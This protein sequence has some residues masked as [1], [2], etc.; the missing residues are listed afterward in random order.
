MHLTRISM[1]V[2]E[3]VQ[4]LNL[5]ASMLRV[6]QWSDTGGTQ[7]RDGHA[8]PM[9]FAIQETLRR[10]SPGSL[11]AEMVDVRPR[12]PTRPEE[13]HHQK[14]VRR[15][16]N[17][18]LNAPQAT[19]RCYGATTI[20]NTSRR[21]EMTAARTPPTNPRRPPLPFG[22]D[23]RSASAGADQSPRRGSARPGVRGCRRIA[24][25]IGIA[26]RS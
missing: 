3:R 5:V 12:Q 13:V 24:T 16:E 1:R 18:K 14:P 20:S 15:L 2:D 10:V 7:N 6:G 11:A 17:T 9:A 4:A 21:S 22:A 26:A 23:P 25:R 8:L 19:R